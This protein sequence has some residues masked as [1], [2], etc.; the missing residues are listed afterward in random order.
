MKTHTLA[1]TGLMLLTQ[2][3]AEIRASSHT[4]LS[5]KQSQVALRGTPED[6][7]RRLSEL[8]SRRGYSVTERK[9]LKGGSSLYVFKGR[10][11]EVTTVMGDRNFV[12]GTTNT[13][14]SVFYAQ[15]IPQ[16]DVVWVN[17][18]GKPTYDG[19]EVCSDEDPSWIPPCEETVTSAMW[20]GWDQVTGREEAEVIRGMLIDMELTP[21]S[22]PGAQMVRLTEPA[23]TEPPKPTCVA[24][25]LPAW[26]TA[27]ALEKKKLLAACRVPAPVNAAQAADSQ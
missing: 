8:F 23:S 3:C 18:F 7:A 25:E 20:S 15:L 10:R 4:R 13:V 24:S 9:S 12:H 22:T 16:E 11:S 27:S 2:G 26:K 5:E 21:E 14:G 6:A 19:Y 1:L 17:L